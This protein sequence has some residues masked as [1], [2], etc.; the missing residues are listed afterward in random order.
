MEIF[1]DFLIRFL[2]SMFCYA[3]FH[4]FINYDYANDDDPITSYYDFE[5]DVIVNKQDLVNSIQIYTMQLEQLQ[6][7]INDL[8]SR[9]DNNILYYPDVAMQ[10]DEESYYNF[11]TRARLEPYLNNFNKTEDVL[12]TLNE[13]L[14]EVD[15]TLSGLNKFWQYLEYLVPFLIST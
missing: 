9:L 11:C 15:I 10:V 4:N 14:I 3:L 8:N 5:K 6:K 1:W 12:K 2:L 13:N 7:I